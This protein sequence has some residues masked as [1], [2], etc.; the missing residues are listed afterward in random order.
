VRKS[1]MARRWAPGRGECLAWTR[2]NTERAPCWAPPS[3]LMC[4]LPDRWPEHEFP[5]SDHD[6]AAG[7]LRAEPVPET[8]LAMWRRP[9]PTFLADLVCDFENFEAVRGHLEPLPARG[10]PRHPQPRWHARL[11]KRRKRNPR[12]SMTSRIGGVY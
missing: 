9:Q 1:S 12:P 6:F 11:Y 7:D 4:W 2:Q 3:G 10:K 5:V 8:T